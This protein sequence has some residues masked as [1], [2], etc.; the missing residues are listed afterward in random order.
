M[1][2]LERQN[3]LELLAAELAGCGGR[4]GRAVLVAGEAGI[5]KTSLVEAFI[6][7][8]LQ[9]WR[10]HR[11]YC[12][13]GAGV[14]AFRPFL[15]FADA[16]DSRLPALLEADA[17]LR[18][19]LPRIREILAGGPRRV[20][21]LE[22]IH[23][24]DDASV[25]LLLFLLRRLEALPLFVLATFRGNE[26]GPGHPLVTPLAEFA[27]APRVRRIDLAP[28]SLAAAGILLGQDDPAV[29]T[30]LHARTAGNPFLLKALAGHAGGA[31]V[32]PSFRDLVAGQLAPLTQAAR[33]FVLVAAL[34]RSVDP[35]LAQALFDD[36]VGLAAAAVQRGLLVQRGEELRFPHELTREAVADLAGLARR[37]LAHRRILDH[38]LASGVTRSEMLAHH[39]IGAGRRE[40]ANLHGLRAARAALARGARSEAASFAAATLSYVGEDTE[41]AAELNEVLAQVHSAGDRHDEAVACY[42]AAGRAWRALGEPEREACC[43][44]R[45]AIDLVRA[46][47]N[48]IADERGARALALLEPR[49]ESRALAT[50]LWSVSYLR[51]LDRDTARCLHLGSRAIAMAERLDDR[52]LLARALMTVGISRLLTDDP[53][54][55][56]QIEQSLLIAEADG[57]TDLIAMTYANLGSTYGEQVRYPQARKWLDTGLRF[58]AERD[59]DQSV[60]YIL[61]WA[62]LVDLHTGEL[63]AAAARAEALL[64]RP[65][66]GA[67]SR[68][69]ALVALGRAS[70]RLGRPE[71]GPALGEALEQARATGT[72]QRLAPACLAAAEAAL[73][74]GE[75]E[76]ARALAE[77]VHDLAV[78]HRHSW[79]AGEAQQV[80]RVTGGAPTRHSWIA[81][82]WG[83]ELGGN[84]RGAAEAWAQRGCPYEQARVLAMGDD[85]ARRQ[86]L[87]IFEALGARPAAARLRRELAR[88]GIR[89]VPRGPRPS[90]RAHP[91]GLTRREAEIAELLSRQAS[92]AEIGQ[93]LGISP[94]TVDHHVSSILAKLDVPSRHH[95]AQALERSLAGEK[96]AP[97]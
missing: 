83:L 25:A 34:V 46:G 95:V 37:A 4:S 63:A 15:D 85:E 18:D 44:S 79:F 52:P 88:Q 76:R 10:L 39:A 45:S 77:E 97:I 56:A 86:A 33:D 12:D 47:R 60:N 6:D 5:G 43:V 62:A 89:T 74:A 73:L 32:P 61:A 94:K 21:V 80:L 72:L 14:L 23:N 54:G 75:P 81:G 92:N 65:A 55:L 78:A 3:E 67:I 68:I 91:G 38:L 49:G 93:S 9:G 82:P 27:T 19:N 31:G 28:L 84:W 59:L 35:G 53:G 17:P 69:M 41:E 58:C 66:V 7:R 8:H 87:S 13:E 71:A 20:L 42:D 11:G 2:I 29:V 16:I 50:A 96:R 22:D 36:W 26:I 70:A 24:A 40:E 48:R 90:T 1:G 64:A 51:M 57:M 30:G